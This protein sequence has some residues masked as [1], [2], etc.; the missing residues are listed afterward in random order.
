MRTNKKIKRSR[1]VNYSMSKALAD[2]YRIEMQDALHEKALS[3]QERN[4]IYQEKQIAEEQEAQRRLQEQEDSYS[5]SDKAKQFGKDLYEGIKNTRWSDI[6]DTYRMFTQRLGE[7]MKDENLEEVRRNQE[8]MDATK[9]MAAYKE[10]QMNK[11][12]IENKLNNA[13]DDSSLTQQQELD[14]RNQLNDLNSRIQKYDKYFLT[15]G[16]SNPIIA[17]QMFDFSNLDAQ[18]DMKLMHVNTMRNVREA[19]T[20]ED[21]KKNP[22]SAFGN[23]LYGTIEL[24]TTPLTFIQDVIDGYISYFT[25]ETE[26]PKHRA[27][28]SGISNLDQNDPLLQKLYKG[29][30]ANNRLAPYKINSEQVGQYKDGQYTPGTWY[31]NLERKKNAASLSFQEK[32]QFLKD[33]KLFDV[34]IVDFEDINP[35]FAAE[36]EQYGQNFSDIIKHPLHGLVETNSTVGMMVYQI[37]ALG[38]DGVAQLAAKRYP[39]IAALSA[40]AATASAL[41]GAYVSRQKETASEAIQ[42][43]A[44]R[45]AQD[46]VKNGGNT[47]L[48]T[49][50]IVEQASLA[51][52]DMSEYVNR[53][54]SA[55]GEQYYEPK[56]QQSL[57]EILKIGTAYNF[58][59][60][61]A[62]FE[63]AKRDSRKGI[64]KLINANNALAASDYVQT[65]PFMSFSGKAVRAGIFGRDSRELLQKQATRNFT[66]NTISD[67]IG[68]YIRGGE[69]TPAQ[70]G[71]EEA[72]SGVL[73]A[74]KDNAINKATK[75]YLQ[76]DITKALMLKDI[77]N[78]T[79]GKV[80]LLGAEGFLEGLEEVDQTMLTNRYKR[81]EFDDYRKNI[82]AFDL[83]E[84]GQD[85]L[86]SLNGI[87][88]MLGINTS[89]PDNADNE[90]RKSFNIGFASSILFSGLSHAKGNIIGQHDDNLSALMQQI[91]DDKVIGKVFAEQ[92]SN[93]QDLTHL[94]IYYDAMTKGKRSALYMKER[95]EFLKQ[96][97]DKDNSLVTDG[98][99][100]ADKRLV[101][102]LDVVLNNKPLQKFV[103]ENTKELQDF[104]KNNGDKDYDAQKWVLINA[105]KAIAD[106]G[107]AN[108]LVSRIGNSATFKFNEMIHK[109]DNLFDTQENADE[110]Q[111]DNFKQQYPKLYDL[112]KFLL[113]KYDKYT[114]SVQQS[115]ISDFVNSGFESQDDYI[116]YQKEQ[117]NNLWSPENREE[118]FNNRYIQTIARRN[119]ASSSKTDFAKELNR[120]YQL[121]DHQNVVDQIFQMQ[122]YGFSQRD[123]VIDRLRA[124]NLN[125]QRHAA[126][127]TLATI[128]NQ[129]LRQQKIQEL[130]GLDI[131]VSR[132]QGMEKAAQEEV[133][134]YTKI[135]DQALG[136]DKI[137]DR[138]SKREKEGDDFREREFDLDELF[139]DEF[140]YDSEFDTV[141]EYANLMMA[142]AIQKPLNLRSSIYMSEY[143]ASPLEIRDMLARQD[144]NE[145][146]YKL[147]DEYLS[148]VDELRQ[149][150]ILDQTIKERQ[151]KERVPEKL[152]KE[153]KKAYILSEI[154]DLEKRRYIANK[155]KTTEPPTPTDVERADNG[156]NEAAQ[157]LENEEKTQ[158]VSAV[159]TENEK[160]LRKKHNI[161]NRKTKAEKEQELNEAR[162]KFEE[163]VSEE[164][165]PI[166]YDE[167]EKNDFIS[168]LLEES[169]NEEESLVQEEDDELLDNTDDEEIEPDADVHED[170]DLESANMKDSNA[171]MDP[172]DP[173]QD[174]EVEEDEDENIT[175]DEE[176]NEYIVNDEESEQ[177]GELSQESFEEEYEQQQLSEL[178][179]A[180]SQ[181]E[182]GAFDGLSVLEETDLANNAII[183]DKNGDRVDTNV[184]ESQ[185]DTLIKHENGIL[186]LNDLIDV[187]TTEEEANDYNIGS[188]I[189]STLFYQPDS[190][191]TIEL[192]VD[193]KP[194]DLPKPL[195]P[196]KQLAQKLQKKGW[197]R[198]T[199]K[200]WIVTQSLEAQ[201]I[202][203]FDYAKDA[204]TVALIIEDDKNCYAVTYRSL[205]TF[206]SEKQN[207]KGEVVE[208]FV[209]NKEQDLRDE[210][211][212]K[213]IDW[214]RLIQLGQ[215]VGVE[216]PQNE[217]KIKKEKKIEIAKKVFE[218]RAQQ[219]AKGLYQ[220]TIGQGSD[221]KFGEWWH[222]LKP[223]TYPLKE[224]DEQYL[225]DKKQR[226]SIIAQAYQ[227][228]RRGA[229]KIGKNPLSIYDIEQQIQL[230][231]QNRNAVIE[232]Y[233]TKTEN[234]KG[235]IQYSFPEKVRTDVKPKKVV[236][237]NGKFNTQFVENTSLHKFTN[238]MEGNSLKEISDKIKQGDVVFGFGLGRFAGNSYEIQKLFTP[239]TEKEYLRNNGKPIG[240]GLAGK[241]YMVINTP[242]NTQVPIMLREQRFNTQT[243]QIEGKTKQIFLDGEDAWSDN[244]KGYGFQECFEIDPN[245]LRPRLLEDLNGYKP[246]IAEV[247]FYMVCQKFDTVS[248]KINS[249]LFI[250]NGV[251]TLLTDQTKFA[252]ANSYLG[253][254]QLYWGPI[255]S[256]GRPDTNNSDN[257]VPLSNYGLIIGMKNEQGVFEPRVYMHDELF[258]VSE[259]AKKDRRDI[260]RAIATQMHWS[261]DSLLLK[262]RVSS[263]NFEEGFSSFVK[264]VL[265]QNLEQE[266]CSFY[267]CPELTIKRSDFETLGSDGLIQNV[268]VQYMAWCLNNGK[269]QT[270]VD[271]KQPLVDPFVFGEG[272]VVPESKKVLDKLG[273]KDGETAQ[274]SE[275]FG[276]DGN[277]LLWKNAEYDAAFWNGQFGTDRR[278]L[279]DRYMKS[280]KRD[281]EIRDAFIKEQNK[282]AGAKKHNGLRDIVVF[283]LPSIDKK[284]QKPDDSVNYL[285][286]Q[287]KDFISK[288]NSAHK[289]KV[290]VRY[291][292]SL[293]DNVYTQLKGGYYNRKA[294][295]ILTIYNDG[296]CSMCVRSMDSKFMQRSEGFT[297]VYSTERGK[298][299]MNPEKARNW[300]VKKLGIP[301][302]N[303]I[304]LNALLKGAD[305]QPVFAVVGMSTD[306]L[307]NEITEG[308][309]VAMSKQAGEGVEYHEGWHYVNLLLHDKNTRKAIYDAY[310][311]TH[312]KFKNGNF[313]Y[314]DVEEALADDFKK[315]VLSKEDTSLLGKVKRAFKNVLDFLLYSSNKALYQQ[316][317][318][319]IQSGKYANIPLDR[320]SK[321]EFR[322]KYAQYGGVY[323]QLRNI[324]G[325]KNETLQNLTSLTSLQDF[326]NTL[327]GCVN[328]ISYELNLDSFEKIKSYNGKNFEEIVAIIKRLRDR[329]TD[330]RYVGFLDDVIDN[331]E[332]IK[333]ALS[334]YLMS[335]NI[336]LKVKKKKSI[337]E[338]NTSPEEIVETDIERETDEALS[339]EEEPD[340]K[341]DEIQLT[342]S[343]KDNVA[344]RAK[345]FLKRLPKLIRRYDED[346]NVFYEEDVDMFGTPTFWKYDE[347][348]NL[349]MNEL[350]DCDSLSETD[351]ETG[352]FLPT[353]IRGKVKKL[354][355]SNAMFYSLDSKLEDI[356]DDIQLRNQIFTTISASKNAVMTAFI[357]DN[358]HRAVYEDQDYSFTDTEN[359]EFLQDDGSVEDRKRLWEWN[360]DSIL[361]VAK[362]IPRKW[363]KNLALNGLIDYNIKSKKSVIN[364]K[365]VE[366]V[367]KQYQ[368][369]KSIIN[370]NASKSR[371]SGQRA[372]D[373]LKLNSVLYGPDGIRQKFISLCSTLGISIDN[374]VL[375]EYITMFAENP[376]NVTLQNQIDA[377]VDI[378]S[379]NSGYIGDII[380]VLVQNNGEQQITRTGNNKTELDQM[381]DGYSENSGIGKLAVAYNNIHPS[382]SEYAVRDA[383]DNLI[384]PINLPDELTDE[385]TRLNKD[386]EHVQQMKSSKLCEHSVILEAAEKV[387]QTSPRTRLVLDTFVGLKDK[388]KLQGTDNS[389]LTT[390]ED[391]L[392]KMFLTEK[393]YIIFP[394]MADKKR[395]RFLKSS[396]IKLSHDLLL[397]SPRKKDE[398]EFV[399]EEY[400][401]IKKYKEEDYQN[402]LQYRSEAYQ[403]YLSLPENNDVRLK[404]HNKAL[405]IT[406]ADGQMTFRRFSKETLER[407]A[408]LFL[409]EINA[410]IEYY[411]QEHIAD[412]IAYPNKL[413]DNF[414]GK[415][416][417][418]RMDFSGNG[419]KFRYFYDTF[420]STAFANSEESDT[421]IGNTLDMNLNQKLQS[422]FEL[423]K[424]IENGKVVGYT[425]DENGRK[426]IDPQR[427]V[428]SIFTVTGKTKE[429]CDGFELIR[430]F[431]NQLKSQVVK[432]GKFT[433]EVLDAVNDK[434][435]KMTESQLQGFSEEGGMF[436]IVSKDEKTGLYSPYKIPS[437]LLKRYLDEILKSNLIEESVTPYSSEET[438]DE[439]FALIQ[440]TYS[441]IANH[442]VNTMLSV[443]EVEKVYTGESA[444]YKKKSGDEKTKCRLCNYE[445]G[446]V[447]IDEEVQVENLQDTFSDKVKRLG[448]PQSTGNKLRLDFTDEEL[449]ID[450]TL[451]STHYTIC[452]VEDVEV[453]SLYLDTIEKQFKTQLVVNYIRSY[454][455][456]EFEKIVK[457][458]IDNKESRNREHVIDKLYKD[459]KFVEKV[460]SMLSPEGKKNV[461][462]GLYAQM[463]PYK[464]I[465]VCD[466]QVFIRPALYR[467]IRISLGE[468]SFEKDETG[469]SDEDAYRICEANDEWMSDPEK[470]SLVRKFQVNALK[471]SYFQNSP[472]NDCGMQINKAIYNKMALFPLFKMHRSTNIG[473]QL[474]DRMNL[475][476][477]EIDMIAFK[478]AVKVGATKNAPHINDGKTLASISKDFLIKTNKDGTKVPVKANS[479][480]I[481]YTTDIIKPNDSKNTLAIGVQNLHNIR[482][483]LNTSAHKADI[484][485]LGT[486]LLKI[487]LSNIIDDAYYGTHKEGRTSRLG[488]DIKKD[489]IRC[490]NRLTNIGIDNIRKEFYTNGKLDDRKVKAY[491]QNIA[492]NN[493][494][495]EITQQL[496]AEG[497]VAASFM[498]RNVF[499]HSSS[500]TVNKE[501]VNVNTKGGTA[502][503]QSVFGFVGYGNE[504]VDEYN[505]DAFVMYNEG[506][507]LQW[508]ANEGSMEVLLSINFF[509][510]VVPKKYQTD[511]KT[512]RQWLIDHDVI[513]GRKSKEYWESDDKPAYANPKPFGVG[514][515]IPTQGMS[516]TFAYTVADVLPESVG[517]LIVVPRE[518]TAQ[519][520]SDF[521]VDKLYLANYSYKIDGDESVREVESAD[522]TTV[523]AFGNTLIDNY[524]DIIS[525]IRNFG[526]SRGSIDVI[527]KTIHEEFIDKVLRD[528]SNQYIEGMME[529]TPIFQASRKLE[530]GVGKTGIGPFALNITNLALTQFVHLTMN[531]GSNIFNLGSL[532]SIEGQD[533]RL[534][535]AW[536]SAM[537]NA[538]VDVA[539]DPYIFDLNINQFT[540]NHANLL[541]RAGKGITTLSF[542][543]QPV[544]K[545]LA[546]YMNNV[547]GIYGNNVDGTTP[548]T[549]SKNNKKKGQVERMFRQYRHALEE[550]IQHDDVLPDIADKARHII[551]WINLNY[552]NSKESSDNKPDISDELSPDISDELSKVF[553]YEVACKAIVD[554]KH[555]TN[556]NDLILAY[557]HQVASLKAF[558]LL[559]KYARELS[560]LVH[561]SGIDTKKFGNTIALQRNFKNGYDSFRATSSLWTINDPQ[562]IE[563]VPIRNENAKKPSAQDISF[564]ALDKYFSETFLDKKFDAALKYTRGILMKQ[565][566]TAT[567]AFDDI[568]TTICSILFGSTEINAVN[569]KSYR[570]YGEIYRDET[571]QMIANGIENII[572]FNVFVNHGKDIV[573]F[574]KNHKSENYIDFIGDGSVSIRENMSRLLFG[575]KDED[576]IFDRVAKLIKNITK[577][578][579]DEKYMDL[580]DVDG[581]IV[582]QFLLYLSPQT[583]NSKFPIGRMTLQTSQ[584]Q[585]PSD[586]Q[587][588]L[589]VDFGQLI[590]SENEEIAKLGRDLAYYAYF[591]TYDQN[592]VDSFFNL[593]PGEFR[594]QYDLSLKHAL[595]H[596]RNIDILSSITGQQYSQ[597]E[598]KQNPELTK[599]SI[600]ARASNE[601]LDILS[602]NFWYNDDIVGRFYTKYN[603]KHPSFNKKSGDVLS[604]AI[605]DDISGRYFNSWIATTR[606]DKLYFKVTKG[607]TTMLYRRIGSVQRT[608]IIDEKESKKRNPKVSTY[609]I[610]AVVPKAGLHSGKINYFEFYC[611]Y[612]TSSIFEQNKIIDSQFALDVVKSNIRQDVSDVAKLDKNN[613]YIID[614]E[615]EDDVIANDTYVSTNS[616]VYVINETLVNHSQEQEMAYAKIA[617]SS[618]NMDKTGV[619]NSD[620]VI[621]FVQEDK[622]SEVNRSGSK[623]LQT[624]TSIVDAVLDGD[625]SNVIKYIA[626]LGKSEV[627]VYVTSAIF[628]GYQAS[629]EEIEALRQKKI[630]ENAESALDDSKLNYEIFGQK[631]EKFL[632]N[633]VLDLKMNNIKVAHLSSPFNYQ[634]QELALAVLK[635]HKTHCDYFTEKAILY[636]SDNF[637]KNKSGFR[638][639]MNKFND[640]LDDVDTLPNGYYES[641][642]EIEE[643]IQKLEQ[644]TERQQNKVANK[645]TNVFMK[646]AS[647]EDVD[648]YEDNIE[649]SSSY[650]E[651]Q[652]DILNSST[653]S[654]DHENC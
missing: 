130:T 440:A 595:S 2:K 159:T 75:K 43:V 385:T 588:R 144:K 193:G 230:L 112:V 208:K 451:K 389:E 626:G 99:V 170:Q 115:H 577:N 116:E 371:K 489:I 630:S 427:G 123:F 501:V 551:D 432:N 31:N 74:L 213:Y 14:L 182:D 282:T 401:K 340:N 613:D 93:I 594:R 511:Y 22:L 26:S 568:F 624:A 428:V 572:R 487:A 134:R 646:A 543:A 204:M 138:N 373:P 445:I 113:D 3:K 430:D 578:P 91:R 273:S 222:G 386:A 309:Y 205:G 176:D 647:L 5:F 272:V 104:E 627:S 516:S 106:A 166:S 17:Q 558:D 88:N 210:L 270:D 155:R 105:A 71:V 616:D 190:E 303:I 362:N 449:S 16:R 549:Q 148:V 21:Y 314:K 260:I 114:S 241:I 602:R 334:D 262:D 33:G 300:L 564:M 581:K 264:A 437:Q 583:A 354:A 183:L 535:S 157:R 308:A 632:N 562:F 542:L 301:E 384:Y 249:E 494:L 547:G 585:T 161:G 597:Q 158:S 242:N 465:T 615:N 507:E 25:G 631:L 117:I 605:R 431:L 333:K 326:F 42:A 226:S 228:A 557:I 649:D 307:M 153:A 215:Q 48:I 415:V 212:L 156:D 128:K 9:L 537:V 382:L 393:D 452:N 603:D 294:L 11:H 360:D 561:K 181:E 143:N 277:E 545:K 453:E 380:N 90:L 101:D 108:E 556:T 269:L 258:S 85:V 67:K 381:F 608:E 265:N 235:Q 19:S 253:G 12:D 288:Y 164:D 411:K 30:V 149:D 478:S 523:G 625:T 302:E 36:H 467:K 474:Y 349:I 394:T 504:I 259:E 590:N 200:Y 178:E 565:L 320:E 374:D 81:G 352:D 471:M 175:Q 124:L 297:G 312:K 539:K 510:S 653:N 351:K 23:D 490:M 141:E 281:K 77:A 145:D 383:N 618:K 387:D 466:A 266:E 375:D 214:N 495:G 475:V 293:I 184:V 533:G 32:K 569:G 407:F 476:G 496:L 239:L 409:D 635:T 328:A 126:L 403:W 140:T 165:T 348:W 80:K 135:I 38:L 436:Q 526:D 87:G 398:I 96:N 388:N 580:V 317:F 203:Y 369:L 76:K 255:D 227:L 406:Q 531:F 399:L 587:R 336:K 554:L 555:S 118:F 229:T 94:G 187:P 322:K 1:F 263:S 7:L 481:D 136:N 530:F 619:N 491:I 591:S 201:K 132:I 392:C 462:T 286:Q 54:T 365:F 147:S 327:D 238:P 122:R 482:L 237:S 586:A 598:Y 574:F 469:Y 485:A 426:V 58:S 261:M 599:K 276:L 251:G 173:E 304:V 640:I 150:D 217:S 45:V 244:K 73:T 576:S 541:F 438:V 444:M 567:D 553:D 34:D 442:T 4:R 186:D 402:Y 146:I 97:L 488:K 329:Q 65:L 434:L 275:V 357:S 24:A 62:A 92:Q 343:Y 206:R 109:V 41:G 505:N 638:S 412:L 570:V 419:G 63:A 637:V 566:F 247:L 441:L 396:N 28:A 111:L 634:K 552:P 584:M 325:V 404:I 521:D 497:A 512:M 283:R 642:Q 305:S 346:G 332:I 223:K 168:Q 129:S 50:Q 573:K 169:E 337:V 379:T 654:K 414:H 330:E 639:V 423:Q 473:R 641:E 518:F 370:S 439:K 40:T 366:K 525:D 532:D 319:D 650:T 49:T 240:V 622:G 601:M 472:F 243:I 292:D 331:P 342:T 180:L 256:E 338:N 199:K 633:L 6:V 483:Q 313:T 60:S 560:S 546:N 172:Q 29:N 607:A 198:S 400:D 589:M 540:Y 220:A 405:E 350:W 27:L 447:L 197:L 72:S 271:M 358:V 468:W 82:N 420:L 236:Q 287:I 195:A 103:K 121:E 216:V 644:E 582:N 460:Y 614:W 628:G 339:K 651:E 579:F 100:D 296:E 600:I 458:Q 323:S 47:K 315:Y 224:N 513:K 191:T 424:K 606:T 78:Y 520:G 390:I 254:K 479:Q 609:N 194:V 643:S 368:D 211:Y 324:P 421:K 397:V 448:G 636:P 267:G 456:P 538:H 221:A 629:K 372:A 13:F 364:K 53:K 174:G 514:Y 246:S 524:I 207:E 410:V 548:E 498:S 248:T 119:A 189:S 219:I 450:P 459:Y 139:P 484:R 171:E 493:G 575:T 356:S 508:I 188:L 318:D 250:H 376:Q 347:A 416:S 621:N 311:K 18:D 377:F 56:D 202:R 44:E 98:Y 151:Q 234:K 177:A 620:C 131:D 163:A 279:Y 506:K 534:I 306:V 299:K 52:L 225:A 461:D 232:A 142:K 8:Y 86:L 341:W 154:K 120:M 519:T 316:I 571:A 280:A 233:L 10:L 59:T 367:S 35:Q 509:K 522:N 15:E 464:N 127:N 291:D 418:S 137:R 70:I 51:G 446:G 617:R 503:Q 492:I 295:P 413:I 160:N 429:Q 457:K 37:P 559:D 196:G 435:L 550:Y 563:S 604:A 417:N 527:T 623:P 321:E 218:A 596:T 592:T 167:E 102:A 69:Y 290:A 185:L 517:D 463:R 480:T 125:D 611:N 95:L 133:D 361:Q 209:H 652:P 84:V 443:M 278:Q 515:R 433:Q 298:G 378:I 425:L 391:I 648:V 274:L 610:Y 536:L 289:D 89:D 612:T 500:S 231:R 179:L 499:E 252:L 64:N 593:V 57:S 502:I 61:D 477:N 192:K 46:V 79:A 470:S 344:I 345:M 335:L 55:S 20:I 257:S 363:S 152:S 395:W 353:S 285:R 454:E 66:K 284:I 544:I 268:P 245:T 68:K 528:K 162:R 83:D 529:L 310:I 408:K 455:V 39:A 645:S 110:Q 355:D 486:Q 422:L 359:I 107:T